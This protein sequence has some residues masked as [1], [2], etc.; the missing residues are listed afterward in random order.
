MHM[1]PQESPKKH[2]QIS[3]GPRRSH[4]HPKGTRCDSLTP[5][6]ATPSLAGPLA[7]PKEYADSPKRKKILSF[8]NTFLSKQIPCISLWSAWCRER[9]HGHRDD[10]RREA[11]RVRWGGSHMLIMLALCFCLISHWLHL[12]LSPYILRTA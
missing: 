9:E 11:R 10:P 5:T 6:L 8:K 7:G 2:P 1:S 3:T 12:C 4:C